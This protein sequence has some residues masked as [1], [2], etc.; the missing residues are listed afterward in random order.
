MNK[1]RDDLPQLNGKTFLTDGGL[2]TTLIFHQEIDLPHFASFDILARPNGKEILRDYYHDY[3]RIAKK[4]KL[5]FVLESPT[6]RANKDWGYKMGYTTESL[7]NINTIAIAHL[8]EIRNDLEDEE[9]PMVISGCIG[10]R[11]DGYLLSD[12]MSVEEARVYHHE[13]ISTFSNSSADL[14]TSHTVNYSSE[15][16]GMV[17]AAMD[18]KMPIAI[19]FTVETDGKLPSGESLKEAIEKVDEVSG[20]YPSY[21]MVNCAHP[22]HF[23]EVLKGNGRWKNRIMAIRANAS[24]KSHAELDECEHLDTGDKYQLAHDYQ[25]LR[26]LLPNLKVVGGCC[27]TDQNHLEEICTHWFESNKN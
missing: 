7:K 3:I 16:L 12:T 14:V 27:G 26:K 17:L 8:D 11:G 25:D 21:Y 19:G 22:T 2:E 9:S 1:Y 6:W 24:T 13:Q 15:A 5:G 18:N 23:K 10:P 20:S 4:Q